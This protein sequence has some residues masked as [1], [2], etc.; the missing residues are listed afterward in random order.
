MRLFVNLNF[1]VVFWVVFSHHLL[2]IYSIALH[3]LI[4]GDNTSLHESIYGLDFLRF[5]RAC[6][7][8]QIL[9]CPDCVKL[10]RFYDVLLVSIDRY[11]IIK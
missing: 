10:E 8:T 4:D 5:N 3:S 1:H 7:L 6:Q 2:S 9:Q 11:F